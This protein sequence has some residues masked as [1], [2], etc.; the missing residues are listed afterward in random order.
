MNLSSTDDLPF[1]IG[2]CVR[3]RARVK[4][5]DWEQDLGGWQGRVLSIA[6]PKRGKPTVMIAWDSVTLRQM[7]AAAIEMCEQSGLDWSELGRVPGGTA[8]LSIRRGDCG[9]SRARSATSGRQAESV[10]HRIGG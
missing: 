9:I 1:K 4:D 10:E 5:P 6:Q 8:R 2:A 7:S 3:V